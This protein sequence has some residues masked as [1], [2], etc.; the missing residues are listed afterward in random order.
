MSL[1]FA[2]ALR[3]SSSSFTKHSTLAFTY[4]WV[5]KSKTRTVRGVEDSKGE[6]ANGSEA[7]Y[8]WVLERVANSRLGRHVKDVREVVLDEEL[9]HCS[10][11]TNVYMLHLNASVLE[12]FARAICDKPPSKKMTPTPAI[13]NEL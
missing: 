12:Q 1:G 10:L 7:T 5:H 6:T 13:S 4:S 9:V 2:G 8:Q 11:V 3:I